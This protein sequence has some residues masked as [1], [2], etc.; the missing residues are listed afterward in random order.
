MY[1]RLKI[2]IDSI[3][4]IDFLKLL[5]VTLKYYKTNLVA[6][7]LRVSSKEEKNR[8]KELTIVVTS[9]VDST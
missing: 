4:T 7:T 2:I 3:G 5:A 8:V 9:R 1:A 6:D